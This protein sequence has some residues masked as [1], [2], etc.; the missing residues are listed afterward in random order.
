MLKD[1]K[2]ENIRVDNDFTSLTVGSEKVVEMSCVDF[3]LTFKWHDSWNTWK[4]FMGAHEI[5]ELTKKSLDMVA[6]ARAGGA[7]KG[8][9]AA[10]GGVGH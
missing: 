8:K 3:A 1:W 9:G 7:S 10:K 2:F 5:I 4:E 6:H